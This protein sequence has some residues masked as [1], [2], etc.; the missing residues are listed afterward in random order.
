M[1]QVISKAGSNV[2]M[3]NTLLECGDSGNR[4]ERR[5]ICRP[6]TESSTLCQMKRDILNDHQLFFGEFFICT[7][8]I[9]NSCF[10]L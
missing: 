9:F 7:G 4:L 3:W 6:N 10:F 5:V 8:N 1:R 2:K